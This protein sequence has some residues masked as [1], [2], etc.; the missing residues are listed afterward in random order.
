MRSKT[1]TSLYLCN[2]CP[3]LSCSRDASFT[4]HMSHMIHMKDRHMV[5]LC[6]HFKS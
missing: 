6:T 5:D 4:K 1:Q 3:E 2:Y